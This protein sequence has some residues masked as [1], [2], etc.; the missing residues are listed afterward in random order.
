M[1]SFNTITSTVLPLR[2][3]DVDT[4]QIIPK[5]FLKSIRLVGFGEFL[6]YGWRYNLDGTKNGDFVLN[7]ERYVGAKVL[8]APANFGIGSS[9]EHA[10]WSLQQ[11]GFEVIISDGFGDIFKSN[12]Y[13]NGL[14]PIELSSGDVECIMRQS[15]DVNTYEIR[16]DLEEQTVHGSDG[17]RFDF[18]IDAFRKRCLLD[19]LDNIALTMQYKKAIEEYEKERR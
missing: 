5:Q 15:E 1:R 9:R 17:G 18:E 13:Q 12:C 4:D 7:Q 11:Y 10:V 19:G 3:A 6:F 14:L 8:V 2:R 16:V